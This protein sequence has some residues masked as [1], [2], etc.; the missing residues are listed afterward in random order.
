MKS[1]VFSIAPGNAHFQ[2]CKEQ[3]FSLF[4]NENMLSVLITKQPFYNTIIGVHSI[5]CVS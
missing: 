1:T 3:I 2:P 5:N 4:L